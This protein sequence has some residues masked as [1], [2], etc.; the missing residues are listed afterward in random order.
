MSNDGKRSYSLTL[1]PC[2]IQDR[3]DWNAGEKRPGKPA[4]T[5][6][7]KLQ[8]THTMLMR[9]FTSMAR[10][11]CHCCQYKP[12]MS[13][14]SRAKPKVYHSCVC[15]LYFGTNIKRLLYVFLLCMPLSISSIIMKQECSGKVSKYYTHRFVMAK[16]F[17]LRS[18]LTVA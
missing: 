8:P 5:S 12:I 15:K 16:A 18:L 1:F 4:K 9:I 14:R 13:T 11:H 6:R 17:C 7:S 10:E 3:E 2:D